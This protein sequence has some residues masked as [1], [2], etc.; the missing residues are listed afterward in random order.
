MA[1]VNL[2]SV[3]FPFRRGSLGFPQPQT[4]SAVVLE[5]AIALLDTA[6]GEIPMG[7]GIGTRIHQFVFETTGP[8]LGARVAKDIRSVIQLKEPR[9]TVL[10]VRTVEKQTRDGVRQ[11][12]DITYE[13]GG[14]QGQVTILI[15]AT[16]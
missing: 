12:V 4:G 8:L 1:T 6:D 2:K 16:G 3:S 10:A 5:D 11:D 14:Q 13:I 7:K 9:M 15:G